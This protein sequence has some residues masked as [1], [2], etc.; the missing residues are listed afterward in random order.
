MATGRFSKVGRMALAVV[1]VALLASVALAASNVKVVG[2]KAVANVVVVTLKN[3]GAA[4]VSGR[5]TVNAIATD[6]HP[7]QSAAMF[8]VGI[9]GQ[10]TAV[11]VFDSMVGSFSA[12][13]CGIV[14]EG[15]PL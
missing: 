6:G 2:S 12:T 5:I 8:S 11:V 15:V 10:T 9:G 14:D 7:M 13:D 4:P 1:A 3:T